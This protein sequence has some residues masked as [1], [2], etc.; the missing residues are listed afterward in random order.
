VDR[1]P[2]RLGFPQEKARGWH[3][4]NVA[5]RGLLMPAYRFLLS[6]GTD[7]APAERIFICIDDEHAESRAERAANRGRFSC[8]EVWRCRRHIC[9]R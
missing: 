8:V 6:D 7:G 9:E 5:R 4:N 2:R 1:L 3:V